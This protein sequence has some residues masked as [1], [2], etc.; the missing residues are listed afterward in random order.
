M[1][2]V[3]LARRVVVGTAFALFVSTAAYA[4]APGAAARDAY[5]KGVDA[6]KAGKWAD[7]ITNLQ[8][9]IAAD[10]RPR[11]YKEGVFDNDYFPQYYLF[12]AYARSGDMPNAAKFSG[13]RNGVPAKIA[14]DA[15][16]ASS[17]FAKWQ[18]TNADA[19]KNAAAYDN[20]MKQGEGALGSKSF[21]AAITAFTDASKVG[22]IDDAKKRAAEQKLAEATKGKNDAATAAA[23][24]NAA[25]ALTTRY[26][27]LIGAGDQANTNKQF[28]QA[29]NSYRQASALPG[30]DAAR[31]T[32]ADNKIT[33]TTTAKNDFERTQNALNAAR[34]TFTDGQ[35]LLADGKLNE[36]KAKFQQA[37]GQSKDLREAS[38]ALNDITK[39]EQD[40]SAAKA[41]GDK[42]AKSNPSGARDEYAKAQRAH[43]QYAERDK[44]ASVIKTIDD[45]LGAAA[46]VNAARSAVDDG[47]KLAQRGDLK[48]ARDK[49]ADALS[50]DKNNAE[51][52]QLLASADKAISDKA[53]A[54]AAVA[55]AKNASN[56]ANSNTNA[57]ASNVNADKLAHDG[58]SALL[59]TGDAAKAIQLLRQAHDAGRFS[60]SG[61]KVT[62]DAYLSVALAAQALQ[63]ND[64]DLKRQ[65][66]QQYKTVPRD[67]KL[68]DKLVS[69]KIRELLG[70]S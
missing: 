24:A 22:G 12:I 69:P 15:S 25:A 61:M 57:V 64:D 58:L 11:S 38:D 26:N 13:A 34:A 51:A 1:S 47:K 35:R 14:N 33:S 43:P 62:V 36:A 55:A 28:D 37:V 60:K 67:Y 2:M 21:D 39:R 6:V 42:L 66:K 31:K 10:G 65:A 32:A 4:Q 53:A 9:A 40:Y 68:D 23:N 45:S 56:N 3:R 63:K 7:A 54:D 18:Q 46:L 29:L 30:L 59:A 20:F 49:Y 70:T 48:G 41:N 16:A 19:A 17:E 5:K 44:L 52:K 27:E 50:K 8:N